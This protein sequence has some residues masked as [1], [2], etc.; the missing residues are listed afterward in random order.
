MT[1]TKS[2]NTLGTEAQMDAAGKSLTEAVVS[3]ISAVCRVQAELSAPQPDVNGAGEKIIGIV[4]LMGDMDMTVFLGIPP[5]TAVVFAAKFAGFA[6]PFE[7]PDMAD[8]V[9]ELTNMIAGDLKIR[10]DRCRIKVN[11]SIPTVFRGQDL[12]ATTP[13]WELINELGFKTEYGHFTAGLC[14]KKKKP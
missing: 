12:I 5:A 1:M 3:V 7:S 13:S 2:T 6:V 14:A 11:I 4:S 10:L 9:G 8:A